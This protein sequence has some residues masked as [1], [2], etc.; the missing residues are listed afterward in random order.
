MFTR[1]YWYY[2]TQ[3]MLTNRERVIF[4]NFLFLAYGEN[5]KLWNRKT[6]LN[7]C[8]SVFDVPIKQIVLLVTY[9]FTY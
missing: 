7:Q 2:R 9:E 5:Q 1:R 4:N 3:Y 8:L 6:T